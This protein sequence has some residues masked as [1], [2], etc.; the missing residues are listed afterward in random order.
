MKHVIA[1]RN[2]S[3]RR[4]CI[5]VRLNR[6]TMTYE[7]LRTSDKIVIE[8]VT[9]L[10]ESKPRWGFR[11]IFEWLRYNDYEWNHKRVRRIYRDL[12]LHHRIR[13]KKRIPTREPKALEVPESQNKMW[14]MD[15]MADSLEVGKKFRV[16]NVI[17]D[18]NREVLAVEIDYSLPAQRVTRVLDQIAEERG[19][20]DEIR[21]D[22]GPEFLSVKLELWAQ[23]HRVRLEHIKPGKPAQNAFIERFNRTYRED[24]LDMYLFRSLDEVRDITTEWMHEYNYERPHSSLG[25]VPPKAALLASSR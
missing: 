5:L 12:K 25:G 4:A 11:K 15:F 10:A 1:E 24:V 23:Q 9:R 19:Y 7:A 22:N 17:D 3:V 13:P 2:Y 18:H 6:G 20:P 14:S 8:I 16:L 21:M